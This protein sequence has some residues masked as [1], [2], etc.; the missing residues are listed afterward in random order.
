MTSLRINSG[1]L[2]SPS[3][4]TSHKNPIIMNKIFRHSAALAVLFFSAAVLGQPSLYA[5]TKTTYS[6]DYKYETV[7]G[8]KIAYVTLGDIKNPPVVLIHGY[9]DSYLSFSQ[10]APRMADAGFY[11]IVPELRGHGKSDKPKEG[12]YT[13]KQ[14]ASDINALLAK[15][16][17]KKASITGHSLGSFIAQNLAANFPDKVSSITL[18]ASAADLKENKTLDWLLNGDGGKFKGV[19]H[20]QELPDDFVVEWTVSS[21]HD[22][23]FV[24][25]TYKNAKALPLYAWQNAANGITANIA[26]L[27]KIKV[28]VEIIWGTQDVFFS[29]KDQISLME[30]LGSDKILFIK[31]EGASHNTHWDKNLDEETAKDIIDF[32]KHGK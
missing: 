3:Q 29:L 27:P 13:V 11:V 23:V 4:L 17:V 7:N 1:N 12:V 8:I 15:L 10:V 25:T 31:K 32:I 9:T 24:E 6:P 2:V 5:K 21:N 19:N 20:S 26:D 16:G 22:P 14:H 28:P 18:I 30:N